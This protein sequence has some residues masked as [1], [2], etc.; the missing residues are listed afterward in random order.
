MS[1]FFTAAFLLLVF[2]AVYVLIGYPLV[3]AGLAA[4]FGKPIHKAP[5]RKTVSILIAVYNGAAVIRPKLESVAALDYP[6]DLLEVLVLSDGSTDGTNE[7]VRGFAGQGM[8]L[9][10]LPRRR[11]AGGAQ[12]RH[13]AQQRRDPGLDRRA[14][15]AGTG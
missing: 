14:P 13:R 15:D 9:I 10:E 4:R 7:I 6:K 11:K 5:A 3:L 12:R 1:T 2:L 8:E